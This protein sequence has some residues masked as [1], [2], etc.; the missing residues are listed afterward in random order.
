[1]YIRKVEVTMTYITEQVKQFPGSLF[2]WAHYPFIL[3]ITLIIRIMHSLFHTKY[4]INNWQIKENNLHEK[5]SVLLE[6]TSLTRRSDIILLK[7]IY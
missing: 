2:W 5:V 3:G 1:M 6:I 4:R 7:G